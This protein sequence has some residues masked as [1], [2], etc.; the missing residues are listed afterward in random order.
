MF[1]VQLSCGFDE[2]RRWLW[3]TEH[4]PAPCA[5]RIERA[6][7]ALPEGCR[8]KGEQAAGAGLQEVLCAKLQGFAVLWQLLQKVTRN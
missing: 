4:L 6:G 2:S 8:E 5:G 3:R 1:N 7:F